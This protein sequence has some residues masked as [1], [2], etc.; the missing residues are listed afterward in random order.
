MFLGGE[1]SFAQAELGDGVECVHD[2]VASVLDTVD[3]VL[4]TGVS[5]LKKNAERTWRG[6]GEDK[7]TWRRAHERRWRG[8]GKDVEGTWK[9]R[10]EER[11][12]G[13]PGM[14][15]VPSGGVEERTWRR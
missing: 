9:G 2:G 1:P 12:R 6:C 13:F 8:R 10:G 4:T 3:G 14:V 15:G 5:V 11:T 7:G